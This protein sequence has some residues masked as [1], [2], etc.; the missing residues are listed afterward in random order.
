[1][2]VWSALHPQCLA[3]T[4]KG[5]P[6]H[7]SKNAKASRQWHWMLPVI[8]RICRWRN[9][10]MK[11]EVDFVLFPLFL[12]TIKF[13]WV[14][15]WTLECGNLHVLHLKRWV[16]SAGS[17]ESVG[18]K[19]P[20]EVHS[21]HQGRRWEMSS[22]VIMRMW[23][24]MTIM[25]IV[26]P[27]FV[28]IVIVVALLHSCFMLL[29]LALVLL[30]LLSSLLLLFVLLNCVVF[31]IF[32]VIIVSSHCD[33]DSDKVEDEEGGNDA[34]RWR[35]HCCP[36][37]T[38]GRPVGI[39]RISELLCVFCW[40]QRNWNLKLRSESCWSNSSGNAPRPSQN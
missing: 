7:A 4:A 37:D 22:I 12:L 11:Y 10:I 36:V 16:R 26:S 6:S 3:R 28:V 13:I 33:D 31:K 39:I 34:G 35:P 30:A 8:K 27:V 17:I 29:P 2:W 9:V 24:L 38:C 19:N 20:W 32:T 1:M 21:G 23:P 40:G 14:S 25:I 5:L 18:S 15:Y